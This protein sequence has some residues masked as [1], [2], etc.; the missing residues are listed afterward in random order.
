MNNYL[1]AQGID[2][3]KESQEWEKRIKEAQAAKK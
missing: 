1:S 2:M 3:K